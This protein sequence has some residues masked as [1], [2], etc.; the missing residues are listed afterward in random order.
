M[1][2]AAISRALGST[3]YGLQT[4]NYAL[5]YLLR[6]HKKYDVQLRNTELPQSEEALYTDHLPDA[7][8]LSRFVAFG[9]V[10]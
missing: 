1:S 6:Q 7:T 3:V 5:A 8:E 2:R 9:D 4:K 10:N